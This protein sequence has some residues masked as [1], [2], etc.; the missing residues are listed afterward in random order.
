MSRTVAILRPEPGNAASCRLAQSLGLTTL[1]LPLFEV[2]PIDW[3]PPDPAGFDALVLT[4]ANALRWGGPGLA[5]LTALPVFAV[6]KATAAAATAHGFRVAMIGENNADALLAQAFAQGVRHALHLGGRETTVE[7]GGVIGR[8]I[9]V[10]ASNA[11]DVAPAAIEQLAGTI[12]ALHSP[13]AGRRLAGLIDTAGIARGRIM[14]AALSRAVA[15][16]AGPGWEAVLIAD[17]P[18]DTV[19]FKQIAQWRSA[20]D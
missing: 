16:A 7:E 5:G 6:G 2:G 11:R 12:A 18:S 10:Y 17:A 14:I 19:L 8:S 3:T 13:R 1:S 15:E 20:S 9:A 4:S